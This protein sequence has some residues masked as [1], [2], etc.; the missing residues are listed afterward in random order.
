[1]TRGGVELLV[2][3]PLREKREAAVVG[4]NLVHQTEANTRGEQAVLHLAPLDEIARP[5]L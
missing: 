4:E 5:V 1:M 3:V 2:A